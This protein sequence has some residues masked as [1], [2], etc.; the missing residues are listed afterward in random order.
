[1]VHRSLV[2]NFPLNQLVNRFKRVFQLLNSEVVSFPRQLEIV[3]NFLQKAIPFKIMCVCMYVCVVC[4]HARAQALS[5]V[6]LR[7]PIDCSPPGS[8]VHGILQARILEWV[9]ILFSRVSS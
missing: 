9:A 6:Q 7:D 4:V 1:M 2:N 5:C 3:G 8:S